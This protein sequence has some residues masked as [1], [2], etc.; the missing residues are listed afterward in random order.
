MNADSVNIYEA[1]T[2]NGILIEGLE[3]KIPVLTQQFSH[4]TAQQIR[5]AAT[6]DPTGDATR[7]LTW[8]LKYIATPLWHMQ[9]HM[10][11]AA[12]TDHTTGINEPPKR[13][14]SDEEVHELAHRSGRDEFEKWYIANTGRTQVDTER[15]LGGSE[16]GSQSDMSGLGGRMEKRIRILDFTDN[17]EDAYKVHD[18]IDKFIKYSRSPK[19]AQFIRDFCGTGEQPPAIAKLCKSPADIMSYSQSS[20]YELIG[21][22]E[23]EHLG[24]TDKS[25]PDSRLQLAL[26]RGEAKIVAQEGK[27]TVFNLESD[28]AAKQLCDNTNWCFARGAFHSYR[29]RGPI[30]IIAREVDGQLESY[31]A[32]HFDAK[33]I[34]DIDD[35]PIDEEHA[36]E[37]LPVMLKVPRFMDLFTG[38]SAEDFIR[39]MIKD[40]KKTLF[41]MSIDDDASGEPIKIDEFVEGMQFDM[42]QIEPEVMWPELLKSIYENSDEDLLLGFI[43]D[44]IK[45]SNHNPPDAEQWKLLQQGRML[46]HVETGDRFQGNKGAVEIH[47]A[48]ESW[49]QHS[50]GFADAYAKS[51][52]DAVVQTDVSDNDNFSSLGWEDLLGNLRN[53]TLPA[54]GDFSAFSRL[55]K[56][57]IRGPQVPLEYFNAIE[58]YIGKDIWRSYKHGATT[59]LRK[60]MRLAVDTHPDASTTIAKVLAAYHIEVDISDRRGLAYNKFRGGEDPRV[61]ASRRGMNVKHVPT[62]KGIYWRDYLH[63]VYKMA[64]KTGNY[65]WDNELSDEEYWN[66]FQPLKG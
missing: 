41:S 11:G 27:Y 57:K 47:Q 9:S 34:K 18:L 43:E 8:I 40:P 7:Y 63:H 19:Y 66:G 38:K 31:V 65:P 39:G 16:I 29:D 54:L 53:P 52:V 51:V 25:I 3:Q 23:A 6:M 58:N 56:D 59:I 32:A 26:Q 5:D 33:E 28:R 17:W 45:N 14:I 12:W 60:L 4:L 15:R 61:V 36:Q 1:Y 24:V 62:F 2:G 48:L 21:R 50:E 20:L 46:G 55:L 22:Y 42:E 13:P 10:Q 44:I 49:I 37:I 35:A 30:F 64:K